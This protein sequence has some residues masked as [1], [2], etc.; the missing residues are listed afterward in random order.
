M[1]ALDVKEHRLETAF[2][3]VGSRRMA[4][5]SN[6]FRHYSFAFAEAVATS[7]TTEPIAPSL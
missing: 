7:T 2:V 6:Y 3:I 4:V 5:H 1:K